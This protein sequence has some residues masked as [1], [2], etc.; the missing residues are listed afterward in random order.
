MSFLCRLWSHFSIQGSIR[1]LMEPDAINMEKTHFPWC[2]YS[3][4]CFS[5]EETL[6]NFF[7]NLIF[8]TLVDFIFFRAV[9][10]LQKNCAEDVEFPYAHCPPNSIS[11]PISWH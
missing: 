1:I 7:F 3:E 5:P 11:P 9:M 6:H 4:P 2:C 10:G 8:Q